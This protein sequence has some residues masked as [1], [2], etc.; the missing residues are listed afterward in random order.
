MHFQKQS[1]K[2]LYF[3]PFIGLKLPGFHIVR[4]QWFCASR[5]TCITSLSHKINECK[6]IALFSLD[7]NRS[8]SYRK[9]IWLA[10][11]QK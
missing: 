3:K 11:T 8:A 9:A 6:T 2:N 5:G 10:A 7:D 4:Q 1:I